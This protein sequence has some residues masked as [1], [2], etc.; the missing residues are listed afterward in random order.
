MPDG[1]RAAALIASLAH[2]QIA[3]I[4]RRTPPS[5]TNQC[6]KPE[7]SFI[8]DAPAAIIAP[9]RTMAGQRW[10]FAAIE[11]PSRPMKMTTTATARSTR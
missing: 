11:R 1:V 10:P 5:A 6:R 9:P 2:G 4:T 8:G 7:G 3:R